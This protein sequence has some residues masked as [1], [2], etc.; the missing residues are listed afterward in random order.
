MADDLEPMRRAGLFVCNA[1]GLRLHNVEVREQL[2]PA[3][4]IADSA[5]VE[6]SAG[7]TRTPA[8]DAPVILLRDVDGAFVH[9]CRASADTGV[10]L[11]VEGQ[12]TSDIVLRG[13]S[14]ARA[15]QP[16]QAAEAV[17]PGAV[18]HDEVVT[19]KDE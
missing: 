12:R 15:R 13:N 11:Q 5:G 3:L 14:L 6:I 17:P 8:A 1:R 10:F 19:Q 7:T 2:G 4:S 16:F 18:W 9:G